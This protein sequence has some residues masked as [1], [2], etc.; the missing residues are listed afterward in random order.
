MAEYFVFENRTD[1]V[2]CI[3]RINN[4]SFFPIRVEKD[5]KQEPEKYNTIKWAEEPIEL[6]TGEF[7]VKK[8]T[9]AFFNHVKESLQNRQIFIRDMQKNKMRISE[10]KND[11]FKWSW[12]TETI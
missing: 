8:P 11:D 4:S 10:L 6:E 1:A 3:D 9:D 12:K 5:G 2:N 7:A